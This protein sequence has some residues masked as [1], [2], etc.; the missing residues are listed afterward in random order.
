MKKFNI[1]AAL[2]A[3][4]M[5]VTSFTGCVTE[6]PDSDIKM[7]PG[8]IAGGFTNYVKDAKAVGNPVNYFVPI[9]YDE[10]D[11]GKVTF[12]YD[13]TKEGWAQA[14]GTIA[15]KF[16]YASDCLLNGAL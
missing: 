9:T 16:T 6:N 13:S 8:Y 5:L 3:F 11:V 14:K 7:L 1:L 2:A 15:F 4:A 12:T 10:N